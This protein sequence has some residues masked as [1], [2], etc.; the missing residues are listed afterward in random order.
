MVGN[1]TNISP[2]EKL[3]VTLAAESVRLL[4]QLAG[5]GSYGMS[6]SEVARGFI[7]TALK[8]LTKKPALEKP[9]AGEKP[10]KAVQRH[11]VLTERAKRRRRG[12][13]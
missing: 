6:K 1:R 7:E 8:K 13:A 10:A 3:R 12:R 11:L 2:S 4:E 5:Y 9:R